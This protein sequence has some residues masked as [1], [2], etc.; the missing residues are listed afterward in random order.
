MR[1][2]M[3]QPCH[4][5]IHDW[6]S[7]LHRD[8]KPILH[9]QLTLLSVGRIGESPVSDSVMNFNYTFNRSDILK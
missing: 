3:T 5:V 9:V 1:V 7:L 8:V 2:D 4:S 6:F